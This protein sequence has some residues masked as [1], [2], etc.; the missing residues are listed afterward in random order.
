MFRPSLSIVAASI[1]CI[2]P[3]AIAAPDAATLTAKL[4]AYI[5]K[6]V[7]A[8]EVPGVA[9]AILR[10]G[11]ILVA[12]GYGLANVEH[13]IPVTP[14]T[15]FQLGSVGKMF[16]AAAVMT[17]VEQGKIRVDDPIVKF[18]PDAPASW[19]DVTVHQL[20]THTAGIPEFG[21]DF[22][23]RSDY[24]DDELVK[25]IGSKPLTFAPGQ[26]WKYSNPGYELLG[27]LVKKATGRS[28]L[29]VLDAEVFKP[30]GMKTARGISDAD[31][32]MHR[33]AGYKFADGKLQNQDWVSPTMNSTAD[34]S[35]YASL[36][37]M[38]AWA[39]GVERGNV[40]SA[41]SWKQVYTPVRLNSGKT[42]PYGYG[43]MLGTAGGKPRLHHGGAWQGFRTYYSRY[44]GDNLSVIV[45]AN[46]GAANVSKIADDVAGLYDP[47]L[48]APPPKPKAE[49][50]IEKQL[51]ELLTK[52]GVGETRP[53]DFSLAGSEWSEITTKYFTPMFKDA[54]ALQKLEL[55]EREELGDDI[56][57]SYDATYANKKLNI[58]YGIGP[59]NG[60]S[61][62]LVSP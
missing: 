42:Y 18:F 6:D 30:L 57:Y 40:L 45:L 3:P 9:I 56:V 61:M 37:D 51:T 14:D 39:R 17:Q 26:R 7:P 44:L 5:A 4:D 58:R 54:G 27:F 11:D 10:G 47:A 34:G 24:S 35:L 8:A 20:L 49:P 62:F 41:A 16:T 32:V 52:V 28:Y 12:K 50:R 21:Q 55:T 59:G 48:I 15:I 31:I 60:V 43:W 36:N 1:L 29:D 13:N 25:I 23:F 22:N 38:I 46:S 53:E 2:A 33:S 19:K